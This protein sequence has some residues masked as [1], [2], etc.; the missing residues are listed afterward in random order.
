MDIAIF[1]AGGFGREIQKLIFEINKSSDSKHNLIGFFDDGLKKGDIV[2]DL[3][4][5]GGIN[6]INN[7]NS[8]LGIILAIGNSVT[9]KKVFEKINNP[10]IKYPTLVHPNTSFN[11]DYNSLGLGTIICEGCIFT[12]NI[13]VGD[14]VIINLQCTVGHDAV[15]E[16]FCSLMPAV[17][18]SGNVHLGKTV[19]VGTGVKFVNDVKIGENTIIGAGAVVSKNLPSNCTAVGVPAKPIKFH[20]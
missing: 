16:D 2:S 15:I 1:G 12:C 18:V 8:D 11:S 13:S 20:Q 10:K 6:E 7:W 14:F 3:S 19:F 4:I 5:L 9:R 17:N